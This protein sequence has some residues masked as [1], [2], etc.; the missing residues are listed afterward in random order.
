MKMVRPE[1]IRDTKEDGMSDL[2]T[3]LENAG[4][5][6]ERQKAEKQTRA[7]KGAH[8]EGTISKLIADSGLE[9]VEN[10]SFLKVLGNGNKRKLLVAKKGGRIDLS[11]FTF[12]HPA[13]LQITEEE[14][15]SKHLGKVR[16]FVNFEASDD[17]VLGVVRDAI[18]LLGQPDPVEERPKAERKAKKAET[19]DTPRVEA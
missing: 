13:V 1:S 17:E 9:T 2:K 12:D 10:T 5:K 8:L 7:V 19:K 3:R 4:K 18:A 14:A 6:A 11:G 16:G 15:K